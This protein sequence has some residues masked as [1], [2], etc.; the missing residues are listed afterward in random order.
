MAS[1]T[2]AVQRAME[3]VQALRW[4]DAAEICTALLAREPGNTPALNVMGMVSG[5]LGQAEQA[6]QF[7]Q[8]AVSLEPANAMYQ[9]NFANA[10]RGVA[11]REEAEAAYRRALEL[12]PEY[13]DAHANLAHLLLE[14]GRLQEAEAAFRGVLK[15]NPDHA[16]ARLN[17]G[18]ILK[19]LRRFEEAEGVYRAALAASPAS[20]ELRNNLGV[21]LFETGRLEESEQELRRALAITPERAE[22][23]ANLAN[24]L[25]NAGRLAEAAQA[26]RRAL[27]LKPELAAVHSILIFTLDLIESVGL[28]EQQAERRRWDERH[29]RPLAPLIRAHANAR[30]PGKRLRI[31]YVSAD[32]RRHSACNVFAPVIFGRDRGRFEV[33]CYSAVKSEDDATARLRQS[34]DAWRSTVGASD[35]AVAEQIRADGIDILVD[36]S[37]HSAGNRLLVFARKPAPVQLSAW[38]HVTGTGLATMDYLLA[39]PVLIPP[40]ARPLF[41]E[42]VVD[43][44]CA[45]CYEAPRYL[46]QAGPLPALARKTL[47]YGCVNRLEK[48]TDQMLGLWGRVLREAPESRLL[49]KDRAL[50]DAGVRQRFLQRLRE[51]GGIEGARVVL[52]GASPHAEHLRIFQQVDVGLDPFPQGGGVSTAEALY[53]GVPVVTLLGAT[54]PAR[55][56][57]SFLTM[58]GMQ[59]WIGENVDDYVRIAVQA[60]RDLPRLAGIRQGLRARAAA[61]A[62]GD[63]PRYVRAVEEAYR[64]A[65]RRWCLGGKAHQ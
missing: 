2:D 20:P 17:L 26:C 25:R 3:H 15:L 28:A 56:T 59:E 44:P 36:L 64:S 30:D 46:P 31:G 6:L 24:T 63:L 51:A 29:A 18:N 9:N 43:L 21:L 62:W 55:I 14:L 16:A 1:P 65:W 13:V 58:V 53:L 39:D 61:S 52:F 41:V 34:A 47:T 60:G 49:V 57:A 27:E 48:V 40:Q 32:F 35:D 19:D 4:A 42:E 7:M 50:G 45:L 38:G 8:R 22:T 54:P 23:H 5:V 37:G 33:L 12:A 11:R 10:L